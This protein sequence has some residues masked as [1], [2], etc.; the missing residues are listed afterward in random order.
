MPLVKLD[1]G[2]SHEKLDRVVRRKKSDH[3]IGS[4]TVK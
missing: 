3:K 1:K 2:Y 4:L